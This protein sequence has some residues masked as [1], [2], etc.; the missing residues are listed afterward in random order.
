[1]KLSDL[2]SRYRHA[3]AA[4]VIK[5]TVPRLVPPDPALLEEA[6]HAPLRRDQHD[7][8]AGLLPC[9]HAIEYRP[10][11]T[12]RALAAEIK[13][14]A[15]NAE[16]CKYPAPSAALVAG[17]QADIVLLSELDVGMAR[18]GNR[19]TAAELAAALGMGYAFAVEYVEL[20]LGDDREKLWHEGQSNAIGLHGNGIL[21]RAPLNDLVV[22]R[23]DEGGRWFAGHQTTMERRIG[24]RMAIGASVQAGASSL[25]VVSVHLESSTDAA[26]RARQV[27]VLLHAVDDC[28]HGR[29]VVIGG[30][31]NT[32]ALPVAE[33]GSRDWF[34]Q[35]AEHELLFA[36]FE[37][38]GYDWRRAN[39]PSATERTR[40]DGTPKPPF[41]KIDWFFT[42]G[43]AASQPRK[44]AAVDA[45]GS[46]ISDHDMLTLT[47]RLDPT[48]PEAGTHGRRV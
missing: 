29:P 10:P 33:E 18:S 12:P 11:P 6:R 35:P 25:F 31:F 38:A 20:G 43:I 24:W 48:S 16:R 2:T 23:I 42:R 19:H 8:F 26:D 41:R 32:S 37:A 40:P 9:L 34:D 13:I 47:A 21:S 45:Q 36:V 3:S 4:N 46:A 15:W 5:R 17:T 22:I 14:A 28:A 39:Q 44:I 27:E 1:M 7:R 30:D